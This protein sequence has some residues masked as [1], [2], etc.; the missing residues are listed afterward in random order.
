[1]KKAKEQLQ[2]FFRE[3]YFNQK[4]YIEKKKAEREVKK[5]QEW[6]EEVLAAL[7]EGVEEE[8]KHLFEAILNNQLDYHIK[9]E[10]A[11][12][13][14]TYS[15]S[16]KKVSKMLAPIVRRLL[17]RL[18]IRKLIPC[19]PMNGPVGLAY[20][21]RYKE[22][23]VE[24]TESK[25]LSIEVVKA[26]VEAGTQRL[27]AR[28]AIEATQDMAAVHGINVEAELCCAL[29]AEVADEINGQW[30]WDLRRIAHEETETIATD[31]HLPFVINRQCNRIAT[32]TRR[33]A[34]TG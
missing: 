19:Q 5:Q 30:I 27:S 6:R 1:M 4:D 28:W 21:L 10:E 17:Y 3:I 29:A 15:A 16:S 18:T 9:N 31:E 26:A 14:K 23:P 32:A 12:T 33:G 25:R 20:K 13:G 7:M 34:V 24:G 2:L 22:N 11:H 8:D